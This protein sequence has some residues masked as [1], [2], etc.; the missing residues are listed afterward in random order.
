MG[1]KPHDL[2]GHT[3]CADRHEGGR[4]N[5]APGGLHRSPP[6]C[7]IC[8][9]DLK[10]KAFRHL[11]RPYLYASERE[12]YMIPKHTKRTRPLWKHKKAT[13]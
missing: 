11:V 9:Q 10:F 12:P 8:R 1:M 4:A 2:T 13:R 7:A 5:V 3:T 6:R